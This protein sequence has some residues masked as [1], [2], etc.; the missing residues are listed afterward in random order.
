MSNAINNSRIWI[1]HSEEDTINLGKKLASFAKQGDSFLL[2][3]TLGM[4]KST[5]ARA[6]IIELTNAQEVPSPT[7]TLVQTYES[8]N[9]DIYHYDLYRIKSPEEVF[10]LGIEDALYQG[11]SLIEWAENM[12]GYIPKK[13]YIVEITPFDTARKITISTQD[14]ANFERLKKL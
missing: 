9:F 3:G 5:L 10:E 12:G 1:S 2:F 6:F 11:V 8:N 4:G 13:S 7:F 14:D